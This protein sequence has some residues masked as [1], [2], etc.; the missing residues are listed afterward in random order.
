MSCLRTEL[1]PQ[2]CLGTFAPVQTL[3]SEYTGPAARLQDWLM[4]AE[5]TTGMLS[6]CVRHTPA[7]FRPGQGGTRSFLA[8]WQ[9]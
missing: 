7:G 4:P 9:P 5:R 3:G 1:C 2:L 8:I 6:L